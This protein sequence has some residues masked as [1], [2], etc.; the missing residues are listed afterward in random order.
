MA[1]KKNSR[2]ERNFHK[3]INYIEKV[4]SI[5]ND[6]VFKANLSVCRF[7]GFDFR[8]SCVIYWARR[9]MFCVQ[10][11]PQRTQREPP[12]PANPSDLINPI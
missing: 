3:S 8:L 10:M 2:A 1:M 6:R 12:R 11:A 4:R 9:R 5:H 7:P